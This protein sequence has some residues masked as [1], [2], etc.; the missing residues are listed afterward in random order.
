MRVKNNS[1]I[2]LGIG[3]GLSSVILSGCTTGSG[4]FLNLGI[5]DA[6]QKSKACVFKQKLGYKKPIASA[7]KFSLPSIGA[8]ATVTGQPIAVD[9][10]TVQSEGSALPISDCGCDAATDSQYYMPT[11][12]PRADV[13]KMSPGELVEPPVNFSSPRQIDDAQLPDINPLP[14]DIATPNLQDT[15]GTFEPIGKYDNEPQ[16]DPS[17]V[18]ESQASES[19]FDESD[20]NDKLSAALAPGHDDIIVND[21]TDTTEQEMADKNHDDEESIFEAAKA[22]KDRKPNF[23]QMT[24]QSKPAPRVAENKTP[25]IVILHARP[26]QSH[27]VFTPEQQQQ[28]SLEA[29]QASHR[30]N[31]RRQNSLRDLQH[32][33]RTY[34]QAMNTDEVIDFKPLPPVKE[35]LPARSAPVNTQ[36]TPLPPQHD[37]APTGNAMNSVMG[38]RTAVNRTRTPILRATTASSASILSLKNLANVISDQRTAEGESSDRNSATSLK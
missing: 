30:M 33:D 26:A 13:L 9:G 35:E 38:H 36:R 4:G 5:V 11:R 3:I 18:S 15:E 10:Y 1:L 32:N 27:N 20:A 8:R 24:Q 23:D 2:A 31:F 16:A 25:K 22:I 7:G 34:R 17:Q 19:E 28:K 14:A 29:M 12:A 37:L 6:L 21:R